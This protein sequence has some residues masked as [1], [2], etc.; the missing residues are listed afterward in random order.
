[1]R[2]VT[3][4]VQNLRTLF[5]NPVLRCETKMLLQIDRDQSPVR[6]PSRSD[7][8]PP[9]ILPCFVPAVTKDV[10]ISSDQPLEI[11][12]E[13]IL[14][15]KDCCNKV[16]SVNNCATWGEKGV[17]FCRTPWNILLHP[18]EVS[19]CHP[20]QGGS[21]TILQFLWEIRIPLMM[22]TVR[23]QPNMTSPRGGAGWL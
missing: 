23:M 5:P 8:F 21:Y 1:M 18:Q 16:I 11:R 14:R 6:D 10:S 15:D 13:C 12:K 3:R 4:F 9:L 19:I 2:Q 20:A 17:E 22:T 7:T